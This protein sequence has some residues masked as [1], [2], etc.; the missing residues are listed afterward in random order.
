MER[1][2]SVVTPRYLATASTMRIAVSTCSC[3]S[4]IASESFS[5]K[6]VRFSRR[7]SSS[8]SAFIRS[9]ISVNSSRV[10]CVTSSWNSISVSMSTESSARIT[11]RVLTVLSPRSTAT[12]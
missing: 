3:V 4:D 5:W 12:S 10:N 11:T 2:S 6:S 1:Y 9:R 7:P 8:P